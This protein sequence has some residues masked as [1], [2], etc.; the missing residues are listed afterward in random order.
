MPR[1]T[2]QK[3]AGILDIDQA[4]TI[5]AKLNAMQHNMNFKQMALNHAP[6]NVVQQAANWCEVCGSGAYE[7]EQ[8]EANPDSVN[9]VG[10]TQRGGV[11]K[12][13][14]NTYNPSCRIHPNFSWGGNQNQNQTQ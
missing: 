4:T 10:N 14:D 5:Y 2:T 12:N 1:T 13:Y 7:T 9:Y 11:Q 8:C 3:A 6:V